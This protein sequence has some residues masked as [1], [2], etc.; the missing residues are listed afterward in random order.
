MTTLIATRHPSVAERRF[1]IGMSVIV[2]ASVFLGF[3]RTYFLKWWF[4]EAASVAPSEP[5]FFYVHG[6]CFTAWML[7][8]V[9]QPVLV[10]NRR[11]DLH[12]RVG[13]FGAG[14][15]AVVVVVGTMGALIAA[16]RPSGFIGVPIPPQQFLAYPMTDLAL[17]AVFVVLAIARRRDT[18]SHK[19]FMLLATI[20]L[21]DA[22][23][24]R[25][26]FVDMAAGIGASLW[27]RTDVGVDLFLV[28]M[29]IWDIV[30][31]GR[32]H[33]VTLFGGLAVIASQPLRVMVSETHAWLNVA[34]WAIGLLGK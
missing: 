19:R 34:G 27:T 26:P 18:Q 7:L 31:R 5:F 9:A 16:H 17:F 4:P 1:Y 10:A 28:P 33:R 6:A 30:S 29:I 13:W 20:G 11:V 2:L 8:L 14:L 24:I 3:A 22:A 12:R 32:V 21:L 25:W 23:V 15:A